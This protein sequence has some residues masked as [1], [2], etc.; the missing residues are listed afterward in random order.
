[1]AQYVYTMRRVQK[2]VPLH[3]DEDDA[4]RAFSLPAG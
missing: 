4:L 1:M 3:P 2:I